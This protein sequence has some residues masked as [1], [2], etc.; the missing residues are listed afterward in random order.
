MFT[1]G[2]SWGAVAEGRGAVAGGGERSLRGGERSL[3]GGGGRR[4]GA[5]RQQGGGGDEGCLGAAGK[6]DYH[7]VKWFTSNPY[8]TPVLNF[9]FGVLKL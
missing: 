8:H 6:I 7:G 9:D 4:E 1:N 2:Q 5:G 3:T